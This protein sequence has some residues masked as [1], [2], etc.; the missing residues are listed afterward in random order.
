ML[1]GSVDNGD[2]GVDGNCLKNDC[3]RMVGF[4]I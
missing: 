4:D 2:C 1:L 3:L